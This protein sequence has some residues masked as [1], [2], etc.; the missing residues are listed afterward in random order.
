MAGHWVVFKRL[1]NCCHFESPQVNRGAIIMVA[2][3]YGMSMIKH[4]SEILNDENQNWSEWRLRLYFTAAKPCG[5]Y[6]LGSL[7]DKGY[8]EN[9][10]CSSQEPIYTAFLHRGRKFKI[11]NYKGIWRIHFRILGNFFQ[12]CTIIFNEFHEKIHHLY[13]YLGE[14]WGQ[15]KS[16]N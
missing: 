2:S 9:K 6:I 1:Q 3:K 8:F 5:S 10:D 4:H 12:F 11:G 7:D 15:W 13:F 16:V 14:L